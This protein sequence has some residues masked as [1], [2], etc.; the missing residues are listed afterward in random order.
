M[1][2]NIQMPSKVLE[3]SAIIGRKKATKSMSYLK[4]STLDHNE[5]LTFGSREKLFRNTM[6]QAL[7][8][9]HQLY[10]HIHCPQYMVIY[11]NPMGLFSIQFFWVLFIL[12]LGKIK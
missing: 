12:I 7:Q 6:F 4:D 3:N 8:D 1:G 2:N 11:G 5:L 10:P 9:N